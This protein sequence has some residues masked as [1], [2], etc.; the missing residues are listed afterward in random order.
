MDGFQFNTRAKTFMSAAIACPSAAN[1]GMAFQQ[2][3]PV[4]FLSR[5]HCV[6]RGSLQNWNNDVLGLGKAA[7]IQQLRLYTNSNNQI[8]EMSGPQYHWLL[9]EMLDS[10]YVDILGD[11][12]ARAAVAGN[13]AFNLDVVIPVA[14][15]LRDAIGLINLQSDTLR[16]TLEVTFANPVAIAGAGASYLINPTLVP[17]LEVF[18]V[19][20]NPRN[21]PRIDLIHQMLGHV[22][23]MP[24]AGQYAYQW[25][26]GNVYLQVAHG[27]GIGSAGADNF[28]F[29]NLRV[30]Q[31]DSLQLTDP[32]YLDRVHW[33][34]RGR[35]R[36][37]GG[38]YWDGMASSGLG[39]YGLTRDLFDSAMVSDL[40]SVITAGAGGNLHTVRRQ[41]VALA[42]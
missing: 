12:D 5:I 19:P 22:E 21:W 13:G 31:S 20:T 26:K 1:G 24:G 40:A 23:V 33:Q 11:T 8:F 30:Q 25:P 17:Y 27:A 14:L 39:T 6:I 38:I 35:A 29:Y 37:P 32:F 34:T 36:P 28:T 10:E 41:L 18:S 9:R 4:G 15:N 16:L 2:L 3:P 42:A 7:F